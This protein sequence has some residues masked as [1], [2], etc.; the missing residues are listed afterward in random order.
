M[1]GDR[2]FDL[3]RDEWIIKLSYTP[4][5]SWLGV[6]LRD[7][8]VLWDANRHEQAGDQ[9]CEWNAF[10]FSPDG[11]LLAVLEK[12]ATLRLFSRETLQPY[13]SA[14]RACDGARDILYSPDGKTIVVV[15]EDAVH[16]LDA[17]TLEGDAVK[18]SADE[19]LTC[20]FSPDGR[21]FAIVAEKSGA[22]LLRTNGN[23]RAIAGG[24]ETHAWAFG[25]D[26]H[27]FAWS[28]QNSVNVWDV[29]RNELRGRFSARGIV[30]ALTWAADGHALG[31]GDDL[32]LFYL[33]E[34]R[35][36]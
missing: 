23:E 36:F 7:E 31:V 17:S 3:P 25:P 12:D 32:G 26:A 27:Y 18:I 2:L 4:D 6:L 24:E 13:G 9:K 19:R 11:A 30:H 10:A 14:R 15:A 21:Q 16:L 1:T 5:G 34:L 35:G 8:F 22:I 33:L 20:G 28:T 29:K